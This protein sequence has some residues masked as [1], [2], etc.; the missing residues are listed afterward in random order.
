[1]MK[2]L[3]LLLLGAAT[4]L[5]ACGPQSFTTALQVRQPSMSGL[6]LAKKTLSVVY[7][8]DPDTLVENRAEQQALLLAAQLEDDYFD[9]RE[10]VNIFKLEKDPAGDYAQADTL[11]R[12][13]LGTGDDVVFLVDTPDAE[14]NYRVYAFDSMSGSDEVRKFSGRGT[15]GRE[16]SP[17][18]KE[19]RFEVLYFDSSR[20][21]AQ[22]ADLA[23]DNKWAEA[24]QL[25]ME[26]ATQGQEVRR[27]SAC[28]NTSLACYLMGDKT[29]A[30]KWLD[31][32][33]ALCPLEQSTYLRRFLATVK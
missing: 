24:A 14:G 20:Q 5:T 33:D 23:Y 8:S 22:A 9:R 7:L 11:I 27:A 1:M 32:A 12:M 26:F 17:G 30:L 18:W 19:V 2:R 10:A 16:F 3:F 31:Q 13:V 6:D 29:L 25:W 4:L 15:P 28:Y 21:W